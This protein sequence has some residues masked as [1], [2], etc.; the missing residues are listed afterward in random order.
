MTPVLRVEE[1]DGSE[2]ATTLDSFV[3]DNLDDPEVVQ[4][5]EALQL[6]ETIAVDEVKITRIA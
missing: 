5:V 1:P 3:E 2:W 4:R 6:D